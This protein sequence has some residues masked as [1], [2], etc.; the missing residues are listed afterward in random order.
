MGR[1]RS[2]SL[3]GFSSHE[4][5]DKIY[6]YRKIQRD[7]LWIGR[8][9][10]PSIDELFSDGNPDPIDPEAKNI[11]HRKLLQVVAAFC[12]LELTPFLNV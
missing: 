5:G 12:A 10:W 9:V 4:S 11:M 2:L 6:Q 1:P 3:C 8:K 7:H